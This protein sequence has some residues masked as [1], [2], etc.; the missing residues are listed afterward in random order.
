MADQEEEEM[1]LPDRWQDAWDATQARIEAHPDFR[2]LI[3]E[4]AVADQPT[5]AKHKYRLNSP[6]YG[7]WLTRGN[8]PLPTKGAKNRRARLLAEKIATE[9]DIY[10]GALPLSEG[11]ARVYGAARDYVRAREAGPR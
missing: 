9:L 10:A 7:M 5:G 2:R 8:R 11:T 6:T 1:A 4:V 3:R